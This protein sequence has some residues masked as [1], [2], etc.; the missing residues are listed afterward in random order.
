[1]LTLLL[2]LI[3]LTSTG[4]PFCQQP[5][6]L[7][8]EPRHDSQHPGVCMCVSIANVQACVC[9]CVSTAN[10]QAFVI[11]LPTLRCAND[12]IATLRCTHT[13]LLLGVCNTIAKT[14]VC[15]TA[16]VCECVCT[17]VCV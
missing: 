14:Q 2:L 10:T 16:C 17:H 8:V 13:I 3:A 1:M 15:V 12:P 7:V 11:Q 9:V 4:A 6:F 5:V